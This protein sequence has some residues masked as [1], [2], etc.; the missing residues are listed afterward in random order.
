MKVI[1]EADSWEELRKFP[2]QT[3]IQQPPEEP[4]LAVSIDG[5]CLSIRATNALHANGVDTVRALTQIHP[6]DLLRFENI[7]SKT[8][9][10]IVMVLYQEGYSFKGTY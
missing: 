6:L 7:G 10:E 5:L 1:F 3:T 9:F 4:L 2:Y 8:A